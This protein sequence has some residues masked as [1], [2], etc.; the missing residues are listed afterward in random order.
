MKDQ[1]RSINLQDYY[2]AEQA[3]QVISRNSGREI[4]IRYIPQLAGYGVLRAVK[5]SGRNFYLKEDVDTYR[6]EPRGVKAARAAKG[7]MKGKSA[8][9]AA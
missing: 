8:G 5:L 7:K 1:S 3:R 6:V 4:D 9:V 2:T